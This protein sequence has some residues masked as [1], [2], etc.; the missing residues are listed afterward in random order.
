M[1]APCLRDAVAW[2]ALNDE[3]TILVADEVVG[4]AT[5]ALIADLFGKDQEEIARRV[6]KL[7]TQMAGVQS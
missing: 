7:R 1:K 2:V 4:M 3:P 6:V 5:V